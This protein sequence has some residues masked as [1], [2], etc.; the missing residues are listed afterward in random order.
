MVV[1]NSKVLA[2]VASFISLS[3]PHIEVKEH[4]LIQTSD[5]YLPKTLDRKRGSSFGAMSVDVGSSYS[6]A[7]TSVS[8]VLRVLSR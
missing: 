7:G 2:H 5:D 3:G 8:V 1:R 6:V 4:G